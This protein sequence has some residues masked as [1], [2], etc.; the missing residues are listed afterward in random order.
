MAIS[1]RCY[2]HCA[3]TLRAERDCT[4]PDWPVQVW[5]AAVLRIDVRIR[6]VRAT[7]AVLACTPCPNL[8]PAHADHLPDAQVCEQARRSRDPRFDGLFFTA[9]QSTRIYCRP[10]CP[11][12]MGEAGRV[13]RQRRGGR[14]GRLSAVP[15]LPA[16]A[17]ARRRHLATRRCRGG[18]RAEADRSGR[19]G[20]ATAGGAGRTRRHGRAAIAA[21]VRR[22][23][24]RRRRSACTA[25]AACCSPSSC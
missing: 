10:V 3:T 23:P 21:A 16:G 20:R 8:S 19:A 12:P 2:R 1:L 5:R 11:A 22:T 4:A 6:R 13:L 14:S 9:V 18:A 15:A 24:R 25:R 17:F 7:A